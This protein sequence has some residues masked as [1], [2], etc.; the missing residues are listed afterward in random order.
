VPA[1]ACAYVEDCFKC[2]SD[3]ICVVNEAWT[4]SHHCVNPS[5]ACSGGCECLEQLVCVGGYSLCGE[6]DDGS[7]A[8]C[9]CTTC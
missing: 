6:F 1:Q 4:T 9:E 5:P 3:T 2:P 8:H 7:A